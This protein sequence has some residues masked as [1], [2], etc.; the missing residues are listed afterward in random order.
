MKIV[1]I[2]SVVS[3]ELA[4]K[5]SGTSIAG[6][7]MQFHVIDELSKYPDV[8]ISVV[9][10]KSRAAFPRDKKIFERKSHI[11]INDRVNAICI[12]YCNLPIVKQIWHTFS[13]WY[14]AD[15]V[16]RK[17][18]IP[19]VLLTYNLFPQTGMAFNKLKEKYKIVGVSLLADLP[20]DDA[21]GRGRIMRLFRKRFDAMTVKYLKRCRNYIVLNA[22]AIKR[23]NLNARYTV[24]D[25]GIDIDNIDISYTPYKP[26]EKNIVY[27]G[28]LVTYNGIIPLL[29]AMDKVADQDVVLDI[30]GDGDLKNFVITAS[31]RNHNI[32][33]HG[34]VS[35]DL[36]EDIYR[37][38]WLLINP[39]YIDDPISQV[40]FPSKMF[41]YLISGTPVLSTHLNGFSSD[42]DEIMFFAYD[43]SPE[44]IAKA[45]DNVAK[46]SIEQMNSKAQKA[47]NFIIEKKNWHYQ[48][49][50]IKKFL[51]DVSSH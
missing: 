1:Y 49:K 14:Q 45:I 23:Y 10:V 8:D 7:K 30:Y 17:E 26:C 12:P 40:T 43:D 33:Y 16:I 6:N 41:E 15:R 13:M 3:E 51:S 24:V 21:A 48:V 18:G 46:L 20:I 34:R 31:E 28:S 29:E 47:K 2:G 27:A 50:T 22:N 44:A 4:E 38:A 39:R 11:Q 5:L 25:G 37:K 19:D 42:Y 32:R 35:S 36:L 9:S